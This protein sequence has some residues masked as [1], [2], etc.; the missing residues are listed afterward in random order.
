LSVNGDNLQFLVVKRFISDHCNRDIP[1]IYEQSIPTNDL[2]DAISKE[3]G[4]EIDIRQLGR[5]LKTIGIMRVRRRRRYRRYY[6]YLGIT[7]KAESPYSPES[8]GD[9]RQTSVSTRHE[10]ADPEPQGNG[11]TYNLSTDVY[12]PKNEE[13]GYMELDPD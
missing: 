9:T 10:K 6:A 2:R 7:F 1:S 12:T 8:D 13:I 11:D 4:R 5:I 3:I